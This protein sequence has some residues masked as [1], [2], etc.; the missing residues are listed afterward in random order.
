M[1]RLTGRRRQR[2][3]W[4]LC[5]TCTVRTSSSRNLTTQETVYSGRSKRVKGVLCVKFRRFT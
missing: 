4:G 5:R 3:H 2:L 1:E